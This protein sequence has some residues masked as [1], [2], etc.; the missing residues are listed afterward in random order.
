MNIKDIL[1]FALISLTVGLVA[2][3]YFNLDIGFLNDIENSLASSGQGGTS[4]TR[5]IG[6]MDSARKQSNSDE[7]LRF[8]KSNTDRKTMALMELSSAKKEGDGT[9]IR[10]AQA[11]LAEIALQEGAA[12]R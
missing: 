8:K 3:H 12:C 6:G 2:N 9:K 5:G 4:S 1:F 7:C 10:E 11:K